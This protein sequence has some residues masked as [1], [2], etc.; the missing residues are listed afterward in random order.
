MKR[1]SHVLAVILATGG[2]AWLGPRPAQAASSS[3]I[4]AWLAQADS[5]AA[6]GRYAAME[7]LATE[8]RAALR[9]A[10]SMD[11]LRWV[12]ATARYLDSYQRR[13]LPRDSL[14]RG[15]GTEALT[16][17]ARL[18]GEH[19]TTTVVLHRVVAWMLANT[20]HPGEAI[21]HLRPAL[22]ISSRHPEWGVRPTVAIRYDLAFNQF[23]LGQ[24]DSALASTQLALSQ[25]AAMPAHDFVIGD[26]LAL[27]GGIYDQLGRDDEALQSFHDAIHEY[28]EQL[29]P[30]APKLAYVYS[31]LAAFHFRRGRY[32]DAYDA[33]AHAADVVPLESGSP[34]ALIVRIGM[35]QS[36]EQMGDLARAKELLE[37]L[38]PRVEKLLGSTAPTVE[39]LRLSLASAYVKEEQY[40]RAHEI[41]ASIRAHHA[42]DAEGSDRTILIATLN[43]D[44]VVWEALGNSDS[45][46]A[47]TRESVALGSGGRVDPQYLVS[48]LSHQMRAYA[49]KREWASVDSADARLA[50]LLDGAAVPANNEVDDAWLARSVVADWRGR[51]ADAFA[52]AATGARLV[53]ERLA[54]NARALSDRQAL[55]LARALSA[56][57]DQM[58]L[59]GAGTGA[60]FNRECWNEVV[61]LR[62]LVR[63]I[64]SRRRLPEGAS[65][66]SAFARLHR[67]WS[68]AE[69]ALASYEVSLAGSPRDATSDSAR[70]ALRTAV[71]DAERRLIRAAPGRAPGADPAGVTLDSILARLAPREALVG[72]LQAPR[73]DSTR[74]LICFV[75]RGG[76]REVKSADLGDVAAL[77]AQVATWQRELAATDP[78][79]RSE[80]ACR[81]AGVQVRLAVWD[82]IAALAGDA[83]EVDVVPDAP[84]EGL[85]WGALPIAGGYLVQ[86]GP[87]V[88]VLGAERELLR[89]SPEPAGRGLLAVGGVDYDRGAGAPLTPVANAAL[90]PMSACDREAL[91]HL[92][93]LPGAAAEARDIESTWRRAC[94]TSGDVTRLEGSAATEDALERLAGRQLVLHLATHGIVL[95]SECAGLSAANGARGVGGVE[96][97]GAA[98]TA[99]KPA[100]AARAQ[101]AAAP[102]RSP[103]ED[104]QVLLA[105]A[106]ANHALDPGHSGPDGLLTA[107]EVTT[108]DLRGVDWVV[109]SAC[110][111]G[112]GEAWSREG[113]L[114]M[115]RAFHL[116]GARTV[117]VS[118]W[119]VDDEATREWM[120]ALYEA[121]GRGLV[122][123]GDAIAAAQRE[124][125]SARARHGRSAHP[126]YWAAFTASGE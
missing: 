47:L 51:P 44:A 41:Y 117:I 67:S 48:P 60:S 94:S 9:G 37:H 116:A 92:P 106:G 66:D 12:Q 124:V 35:A 120:R 16:M 107:E 38:L 1:G 61:G 57:L 53:R 14:A 46:I 55:G 102:E 86:K 23:A 97:V 105:L 62:G 26:A 111:T 104:R 90:A 58:L 27:A 15:A 100:A 29:G 20:Q 25:R 49:M 125:I 22:A 75:A 114:G 122:R 93:P 8:A 85:P 17:L 81:Q 28:I 36:L 19:D 82:R 24:L 76:S 4:D 77:G 70:A 126:F 88:R 59:L 45:V 11:T 64:V 113:V 108:L 6:H 84:V 83:R 39:S 80:G 56:P 95:G 30:G 21:D 119:A 50:A 31:R 65:E 54:L 101:P 42:S 2:L 7:S 98:P 74:H 78:A 34:N 5:M 99:A 63:A 3:T 13:L 40:D 109:L 121:R 91:T 89:G 18:R 10:T 71:D 32:A 115:Q 103:W 43:S 52:A 79:S 69:Q 73:R 110:H 118:Q 68:D 96:P 112:V 72:F 87:L 123:A 33:Y